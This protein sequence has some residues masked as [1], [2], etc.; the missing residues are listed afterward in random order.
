MFKQAWQSWRRAKAVALLVAVALAIGIG[1]A[2]SIYTVVSAVMLKPLP[3]RDGDRFVAL[4]G[5]TFNDPKHYS[6]LS[7]VD[8]ETY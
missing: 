2:T 3:Y 6:S 1:S 8:A 5:S 4:F 7:Y